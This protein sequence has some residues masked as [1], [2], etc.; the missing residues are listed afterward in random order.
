MRSEIGKL[1]LDN[2]FEER[3]SLNSKIVAAIEKESEDWGISALR[4]E[5]KDIDPPSNISNAM[6]LQAQAERN[7]RA[8][9]LASEG[10]RISNINQAEAEKQSQILKAEGEAQGQIAQ[11]KAQANALKLVDE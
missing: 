8:S 11:A 4:Y 7:K 5:I 2:L 10:E 3:E 1:T 6:I 9:I